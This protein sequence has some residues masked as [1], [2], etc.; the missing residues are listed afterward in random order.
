MKKNVSLAI[1]FILLTMMACTIFIGGPEYPDRSVPV[2]TEAVGDL[3]QSIAEAIAAGAVTGEVTITI[4][5]VQLTSYLAM[6]LQAQADPLLTDPQ[7]YLQD[8]QIQ[9]YGRAHKGN[10][11]ATALI[12][13]TAGVDENGDLDIQLASANFGPL[14]VPT[15][16]LEVL[17]AMIDE[18]F[19]G[20]VGPVATGIRLTDVTI[21]DGV[22]TIRGEIK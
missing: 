8:G 2:S 12:I 14:P 17:T 5:E 16:L 11:E 7:V 18:A 4:S 19:T 20:S 3:Q 1:L 6:K 10:L 22:M 13:L 21:A 9:V 15:G